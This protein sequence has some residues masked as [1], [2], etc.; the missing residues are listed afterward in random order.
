[1]YQ[2]FEAKSAA[3]RKSARPTKV[4]VGAIASGPMYRSSKPI[5]PLTPRTISNSDATMIAPCICN[6]RRNIPTASYFV[7]VCCG[8][9]DVLW[10]FLM[11]RT[12]RGYESSD[13]PM[14]KVGLFQI[15]V[16]GSNFCRT[17]F[18]TSP[19]THRTLACWVVRLQRLLIR[20]SMC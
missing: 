14:Y 1:M 9:R 7:I 6:N 12:L 18:V 16:H 2:F 5:S 20:C 4:M 15:P 19:M 3:A 10:G 11:T 13:M 8:Q 17:P